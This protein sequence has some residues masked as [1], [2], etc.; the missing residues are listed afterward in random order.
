[1]IVAFLLTF[2]T[3]HLGKAIFPKMKDI[4]KQNSFR[5]DFETIAQSSSLEYK[6]QD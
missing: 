5:S 1:M 4:K 6:T 3:A 2:A